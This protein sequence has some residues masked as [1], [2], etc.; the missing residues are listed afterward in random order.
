MS[1]FCWALLSSSGRRGGAV[2][3]GLVLFIAWLEWVFPLTFFLRGSLWVF[4]WLQL[5]ACH[6]YYTWALWVC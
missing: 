4:H 5:K 2:S 6:T 1:P 3:W